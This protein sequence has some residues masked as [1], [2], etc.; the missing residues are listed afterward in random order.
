MVKIVRC[1][2]RR[3]AVNEGDTVKLFITASSILEGQLTLW[4]QLIDL[5]DPHHQFQRIIDNAIQDQ[6]EI[7]E[8]VND[9]EDSTFPD[10]TVCL[11]RYSCDNRWYRGRV[12][13]QCHKDSY[14]VHFMD[15]GNVD[16]VSQRDIK[17]MPAAVSESNFPALA[18]RFYIDGIS[19]KGVVWKAEEL[20]AIEKVTVYRELTVQISKVISDQRFLIHSK[21]IVSSL[22]G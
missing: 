10:D 7:S 12:M 18:C 22:Q 3:R 8:F 6:S 21:T 19:P 2:S 17:A 13:N 14:R 9:E 20:H 11:V 1:H 5:D 4:G 15:F 16:I